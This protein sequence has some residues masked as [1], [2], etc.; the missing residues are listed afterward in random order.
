MITKLILVAVVAGLLG[1]SSAMAQRNYDPKT[2]ETIEG[3][4]LSV[5]KTSSGEQRGRGIH[6]AVKTE[7]ETI[8]VHLG[9]AWYLEKQTLQIKANDVVSVTGSRVTVDGKPSIIAA[10]VKK[11]DE[12]L[13]LRDENG[14][15]AWRGAGR[16][17]HTRVLNATRAILETEQQTEEANRK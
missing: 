6:L 12:I 3:N 7:K 2:V 15:P 8:S 5:D 17:S 14:I 11:G 13:K 9:P 16:R 1:I 10:Q 4:V